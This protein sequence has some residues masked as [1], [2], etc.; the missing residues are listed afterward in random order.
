R[1]RN[2]E[3]TGH[4]PLRRAHRRPGHP[5]GEGG[6]GGPAPAQRGAGRDHGGDHAQR[7]HRPLGPPGG[8]HRRR[9][10]REREGKFETSHAGGDP[11]VRT[12]DRKLLRE[13]WDLRAQI[14]AIVLVIA[15]GIGAFVALTSVW[16]S[17]DR[18]RSEFYADYR[19]GD[20][21]ASLVR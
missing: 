14:L 3:E 21:F 5:D 20:L 12:L 11:L 6:P 19:F 16:Y 17:L 18:A 7:G 10:D 15:S 9:T 13:L 8:D 1:A 4:P 2:R